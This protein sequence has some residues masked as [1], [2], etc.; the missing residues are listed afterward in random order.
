MKKKSIKKLAI[1]SAA[2]KRNWISKYE[3]RAYIK[4]FVKGAK[5][6]LKKR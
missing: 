6:R 3:W 5:M 1:K 2:P 4:G